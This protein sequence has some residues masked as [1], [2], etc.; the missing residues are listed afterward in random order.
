MI[1]SELVF[2]FKD[3]IYVMSCMLNMNPVLV[4]DMLKFDVISIDCNDGW[5]LVGQLWM[6]KTYK[7]HR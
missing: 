6:G 4:F 7:W 2:K 5:F 3:D 1:W